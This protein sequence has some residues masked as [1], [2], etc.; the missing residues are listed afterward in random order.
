MSCRASRH[1]VEGYAGLERV[2]PKGYSRHREPNN[3]LIKTPQRRRV[4]P[5]G[6]DRVQ[7]PVVRGSRNVFEV[8][9]QL[10]SGRQ[11]MTCRADI[12]PHANRGQ[13]GQNTQ[14]SPAGV[15]VGDGGCHPATGTIGPDDPRNTPEIGSFPPRAEYR[16]MG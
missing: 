14:K 12:P 5:P 15:T 10:Y 9:L 1:S 2:R 6:S 3:P 8:V 16:S 7:R 11:G 13:N 4:P